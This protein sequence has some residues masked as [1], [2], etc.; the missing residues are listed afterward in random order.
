M[1]GGLSLG[2]NTII[3]VFTIEL[4]H[5]KWR[6]ILG[7]LLCEGFW[8]IGHATLGG[9]VY[10]VRNMKTLEMVIALSATPFML[11]WYFMPESPRWL[12]TKGKKEKVLDKNAFLFYQEL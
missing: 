1:C 6:P 3:A 8:N 9:L 10:G 12:L 5:G 7:H 11:L 2:Y 4:T